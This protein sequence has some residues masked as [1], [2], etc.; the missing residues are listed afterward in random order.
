[1]Q[2]RLLLYKLTYYLFQSLIDFATTYQF[3][4]ARCTKGDVKR[5]FSNKHLKLIYKLLSFTS[6]NKLITI[7]YNIPYSIKDDTQKIIEVEVDQETIGSLLSTYQIQYYNIVKVLEFLIGYSPF[8]HSLL[9][10]LVRQF[11]RASNDNQ[12]YNEIH[13]IDQQQKI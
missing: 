4:S 2:K 9:Y 13:T 3:L 5:F 11:S 12:I 1:M 6:Y 7:I 10:A 8:K